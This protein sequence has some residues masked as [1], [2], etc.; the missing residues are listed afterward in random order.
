[1]THLTKVRS[2]DLTA[3]IGKQLVLYP[4]P[5]QLGT[6]LTIIL[7]MRQH[8]PQAQD[9]LKQLDMNYRISLTWL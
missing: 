1:M 3:V 5:P 7:V 4:P 6:S 8:F 2:H 9:T